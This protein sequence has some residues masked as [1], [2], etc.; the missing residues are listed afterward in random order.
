MNYT[1][2]QSACSPK[3][4]FPC[5]HSRDKKKVQAIS[6]FISKKRRLS[7][8]CFSE[9]CVL[10]KEDMEGG[11]LCVRDISQLINCHLSIDK[12]LNNI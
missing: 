7:L 8:H 6:Q 11:E 1:F 5:L 4:Q 10:K 9:L 2:D 3:G 12:M